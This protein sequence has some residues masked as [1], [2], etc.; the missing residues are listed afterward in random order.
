M[1]TIDL[2]VWDWNGTLL[3]DRALCIDVINGMLR[4]RDLPQLDEE[5]YLSI[6]S[7]PIRRYYQNVGFDFDVDPFPELAVEYLDE[8]NSRVGECRLQPGARET[9]QKLAG[10]GI[11][12][13]ILSASEQSSLE[14]AVQTHRIADDF[15]A[16]WG[17]A[18]GHAAS[19]LEVGKNRIYSRGVEADRILMIGDTDHDGEVADALGID[20]ILVACGHQSIQRLRETGRPVVGT[21]AE[22]ARQIDIRTRAK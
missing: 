2:V 18:D 14:V 21:F 15:S 10:A 22:V 8:Y 5:R 12:Q 13:V 3:D 7:F 4:R 11:D 16:L 19:K 17:L 20:L 6:F 9:I 1:A